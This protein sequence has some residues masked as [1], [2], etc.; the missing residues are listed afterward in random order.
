ML[1]DKKINGEWPK[2]CRFCAQ[3]S[4]FSV[5]RQAQNSTLCA[6]N[7]TFSVLRQAQNSPFFLLAFLL[8]TLAARSKIQ[9]QIIGTMA[10]TNSPMP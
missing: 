2:C 3:N 7:S 6:Q 1:K 9:K 8:A 10:D 5:L 4:T